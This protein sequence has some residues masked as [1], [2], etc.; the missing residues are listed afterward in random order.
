MVT[1]RFWINRINS[2]WGRRSI[3]WLAGVRRAGK[4]VLCRSLPGV[5]YFDCELPRLRRRMEDPQ[6]FLEGL[7]GRRAAL[8]EIHRLGN[9]SELLKIAAD[10]FPDVRIIATGSSS[11]GA[12]TKFGDTLTGRKTDIWLTPML[13]SELRDFG[14]DDIQHRML[15][16]GLPPF[17]RS[18]E[19]AEAGFQEWLDSYWARDI[20]ELFRL[21]R[22]TSFQKFVELALAGSG[23]IFEATSFS[24]PCE[25]SRQTIANYLGVLEATFVAH[26]MRPYTTRRVS[27][28][29]SAPKVYAFDTGFVCAARGWDSLRP[30]DL[31]RLWEHLVLN[32]LQARLGRQAVK[33]WRDKR[34]HEVDFVV[35]RRGKPPAAVECKWSGD[36]FD[37]A[38]IRAFRRQYPS[39]ENIVAAR[40]VERPYKRRFGDVAVEFHSAE[41]LMGKLGVAP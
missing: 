6:E 18:G 15:H 12:S 23:G 22:R 25:V 29:V 17:F 28:I 27:E 10:H 1:R 9:P 40:D 16:G 32:E 30:E 34:G 26:V 4:T 8:D 37:P 41:S 39:G 20:Q 38:G 5:E 14:D 21:E 33:Y 7:R 3:V 2:A 35:D 36:R 19:P 13:L 11:L 24:G 31:G